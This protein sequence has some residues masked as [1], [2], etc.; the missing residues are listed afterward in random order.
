MHGTR[1]L[2]YGKGRV[3]CCLRPRC[4]F[5]PNHSYHHE[6][7]YCDMFYLRTAV[8]TNHLPSLPSP[9]VCPGPL[10]PAKVYRR[11]PLYSTWF[12]FSVV[13]IVSLP[14]SEVAPLRVPEPVANR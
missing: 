12:P 3:P 14:G 6:K 2:P 4:L 1:P 7:R 13:C 10:S 8:A 5:T 11:C 9:F